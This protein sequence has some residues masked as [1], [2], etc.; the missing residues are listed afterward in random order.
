MSR[1]GSRNTVPELVVRRL[2]WSMGYRYRLHRRDLPGT[3]D[4]VFI[5]KR[6]AIF[7]HG[8]FWHRHIDCRK[9]SIPKTRT[10]FWR[11]KLEANVKRDLRKFQELTQLGWKCQVIWECETSDIGL[12]RNKVEAL[13][14]Q[15]NRTREV[16]EEGAK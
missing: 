6:L 15:A 4:I 5:G 10:E 8:C 13:M 1:I 11:A 9:S 2:L 14:N 7:V 3:P 12:L 16:P